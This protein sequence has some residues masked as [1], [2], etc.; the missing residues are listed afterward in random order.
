VQHNFIHNYVLF[1]YKPFQEIDLKLKS[2]YI[3]DSASNSFI[4]KYAL[5][6]RKTDKYIWRDILD[7]GISDNDGNVLDYPFLNG[8]RYA[9]QRLVFNVL[10]EKNKT[11]KYKLNVNDIS[12]IDSLNSV[13]DYFGDIV[14]DLFGNNNDTNLDDPFK[15][16]TDEKC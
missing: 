3:E 4:P 14:N 9:Y 12:N 10:T 7:L 5:Y 8:S 16:Y 13:D 1:K 15:T 2:S 11:K 6:S